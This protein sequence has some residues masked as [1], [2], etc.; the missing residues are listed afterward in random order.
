IL[1]DIRKSHENDIESISDTND[2]T[3]MVNDLHRLMNSSG[4][5]VDKFIEIFCNSFQLKYKKLSEEEK[6]FLRKL[7]KKSPLITH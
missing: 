4:N 7:F 3:K 6:E 5:K 1:K 2:N